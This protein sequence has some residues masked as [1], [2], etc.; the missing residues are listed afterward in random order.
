MALEIFIVT[1][2]VG[3]FFPD[4]FPFRGTW[5]HSSCLISLPPVSGISPE[6]LNLSSAAQQP[7]SSCWPKLDPKAWS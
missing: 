3:F 5:N 7:S 4:L 2:T 6:L 1:D